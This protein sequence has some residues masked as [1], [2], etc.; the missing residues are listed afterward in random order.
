MVRPSQSDADAPGGGPALDLGKGAGAP[1]AAGG[2]VLINSGC[3]QAHTARIT[4]VPNPT[5]TGPGVVRLSDPSRCR[6]A[7]MPRGGVGL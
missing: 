2:A 1:G 3:G 4:K 7:P 5:P 6:H